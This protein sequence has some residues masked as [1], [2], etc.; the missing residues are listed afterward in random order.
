MRKELSR[1]QGE[2]DGKKPESK[3]FTQFERWWY[4]RETLKKGPVIASEARQTKRYQRN[5]YFIDRRAA[6]LLAMTS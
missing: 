2:P 6:S 1:P 5:P 4:S 3:E